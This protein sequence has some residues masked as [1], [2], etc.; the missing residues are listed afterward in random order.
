MAR[1]ALGSFVRLAY[2]RS[3]GVDLSL[4]S[5]PLKMFSICKVKMI[6]LG[7]QVDLWFQFDDEASFYCE[8]QTTTKACPPCGLRECENRDQH[9][10]KK[11]IDK[12]NTYDIR[13]K[14]V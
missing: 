13:F 11:H 14:H 7:L 2:L 12:K 5:K 10:R 8:A 1:C 3:F 6:G 4:M 9:G